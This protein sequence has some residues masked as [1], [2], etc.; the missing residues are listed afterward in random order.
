MEKNKNI[1]IMIIG[2]GSVGKTSILS[3][4]DNRKFSKGH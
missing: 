4:F 1:N 3:N 2:D